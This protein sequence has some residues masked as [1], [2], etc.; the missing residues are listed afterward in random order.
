VEEYLIELPDNAKYGVHISGGLDSAILL[1]GLGVYK[2]NSSF[3]ILTGCRHNDGMYNRKNAIEVVGIVK[4]LTNINIIDHQFMVHDNRMSGRQNRPL[5][6]QEYSKKHNLDFWVGGKTSNPR[7]DLGP[8]RDTSRD[9]NEHSVRVGNYFNPFI[10]IDKKQIAAWYTEYN[11]MDILY[12]I[13]ISCEAFV[14]PRPCGGCWWC[15]EKEWAFG[16]I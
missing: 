15:K 2:P 6:V 5:Y 4:L 3:F 12:P 14:P 9:G 16:N 13:T 1:Y 8:G 10:N 11:L 7:D